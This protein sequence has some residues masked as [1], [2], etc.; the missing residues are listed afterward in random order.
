[1]MLT[2]PEIKGDKAKEIINDT[3]IIA[4]PINPRK[5]LNNSLPLR[6]L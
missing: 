1:M 5:S 3:E 2:K 4:L 6:D